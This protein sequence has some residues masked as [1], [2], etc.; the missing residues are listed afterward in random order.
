MTTP[1]P[2]PTPTPAAEDEGGGLN[3][4]VVAAGIMVGAIIFFVI[5]IVC[6]KRAIARTSSEG[7]RK[8]QRQREKKQRK[9][10]LKEK[11]K[12]AHAGG[13]DDD[14]DSEDDEKKQAEKA[15]RM[16]SSDGGEESDTMSGGSPLSNASPAAITVLSDSDAGSLKGASP[17]HA[18]TS[19]RLNPQRAAERRGLKLEEDSD[20]DDLL[21]FR[22]SG[23]Q[24][25]VRGAEQQEGDPLELLERGLLLP[26]GAGS[27]DEHRSRTVNRATYVPAPSVRRAI[28]RDYVPPP[29][30]VISW[31]PAAGEFEY[32]SR[33]DKVRMQHQAD[34]E[35]AEETR[36]AEERAAREAQARKEIAAAKLPPCVAGSHQLESDRPL[37]GRHNYWAR[38][39]G[40][41]KLVKGQGRWSNT[42]PGVFH[43][44][45]L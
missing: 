41:E 33:E 14:S 21:G 28:P 12:K 44:M 38:P 22:R 17:R 40:D 37:A 1:A 5:A 15:V 10:R 29:L 2:P 7:R 24:Y 9:R 6:C 26:M 45:K 8:K 32:V 36:Q 30:P 18:E 27:H 19:G 39:T 3:F 25:K 34:L 16:M 13:G 4:L 23:I 43:S 35:A 31:N 42:E 11:E 20:D